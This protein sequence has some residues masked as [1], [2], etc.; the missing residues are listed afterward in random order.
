LKEK[1]LKM[2][3]FRTDRL[4]M[5][6]ALL[7]LGSMSAFG[8]TLFFAYGELIP[9]NTPAF[10]P[11]GTST[12]VSATENGAANTALANLA[13]GS[14][15][16][17]NAGVNASGGGV[18]ESIAQLG[19][20]VNANGTTASGLTGLSL[21]VN[22]SVD[23]TSSFTNPGDN[24]T[25]LWVFIFQPGTFD[26][27]QFTTPGNVLYSEGFLLG[28]G[29]NTAVADALSTANDV[30]IA[31]TFGDG[32]ENIPLIIPFANLA[33][34]FQIETV[35]I[36]SESPS[37][38]STWS[39]DFSHTA[40]ISLSAPGANLYSQSGVLPGTAAPEP[41]GLLLAGLGMAMLAAGAWW[42]ARRA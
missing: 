15:G 14:I 26:Q 18:Q 42:K 21:G 6:L 40:S 7:V 30:R 39:A 41:G 10:P 24:F 2:I 34:S 9:G 38:G 12:S 1:R 27:S 3:R 32:A 13:T 11:P 23:G 4:L 25:L 35:L 19:D 17:L 33:S 20:T 22:I 29:T 31:G 28:N 8:D 5:P 16:V 37:P 36:S